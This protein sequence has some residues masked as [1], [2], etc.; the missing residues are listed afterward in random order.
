L[1]ASQILGWADAFFER[2]GAWPNWQSG[3]IRE[4]PGE[5]WYTVAAAL[6]LG[7]RGLP[8]GGSLAGLIEERR[9]RSELADRSFSITQILAWADAWEA[10]AG[11]APKKNSGRIPNSGG[12][13]WSAVNFA[14]KTGGGVLPGGSSLARLL[15]AEKGVPRHPPVTEKQILFWADAD[16]RR[17]GRWP[18]AQSRPIP[19][20][21]GETWRLLDSALKR[22]IRALPGGSSLA[23]LLVTHRGP[24]TQ[25]DVKERRALTIPEMLAWADAHHA[26]MGQWP[27]AKSGSIPEA[28]GVSWRSVQRAFIRGTRGLARG[29]SVARLLAE[30]RG[31]P[32]RGWGG[33]KKIVANPVLYSI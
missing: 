2:S 4:S 27:D 32:Y 13:T 11:R 3:P 28:P 33:G 24:E 17:N 21:H 14:L 20:A 8:H 12:V 30:Q 6:G 18:R 9:G 23:E 29:S 5:T 1:S 25:I 7:L 15:L 16:Y 22:G 19:G 10:K 26:R 31:V